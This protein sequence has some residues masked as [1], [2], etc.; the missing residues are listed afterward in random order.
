MPSS[1]WGAPLGAG[2]AAPSFLSR[3]RRGGRGDAYSYFV[4]VTCGREARR[5][6]GKGG[7]GGGCMVWAAVL[8]RVGRQMALKGGVMEVVF[9]PV[10]LD[11]H[12]VRRCL[13]VVP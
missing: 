3:K 11:D 8:G 4:T 1:A 7:M 12:V 9:E 6:E 2:A 13:G 10:V 5:E